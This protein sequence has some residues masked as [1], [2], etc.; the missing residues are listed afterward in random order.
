MSIRYTAGQCG[1]APATGD[2][3]LRLL[4]SLQALP[5]LHAAQIAATRT[6][7]G[8]VDMECLAHLEHLALGFEELTL[9]TGSWDSSVG[10]LKSLNVIVETP[11]P[12]T[13]C[14]QRMCDLL[15]VY[16]ILT[17][18]C[19]TEAGLFQAGGDTAAHEGW[20]DHDM[21]QRVPFSKEVAALEGRLA[22][23]V[24]PEAA[25]W[26]KEGGSRGPGNVV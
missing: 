7:L 5:S 10:K 19:C 14:I 26:R 24:G 18:A 21:H 23:H 2:D 22:A 8:P 3:V 1:G 9:R 15:L 17:F 25:K 16:S 4:Q 6:S 13:V 12:E 11:S 20:T